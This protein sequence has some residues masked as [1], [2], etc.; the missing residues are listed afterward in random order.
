MMTWIT[1]I[2]VIRFANRMQKFRLFPKWKVEESSCQFKWSRNVE[3]TLA[4]PLILV[5]DDEAVKSIYL[6]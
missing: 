5:H 1:L 3:M 4:T 2:E 6:M